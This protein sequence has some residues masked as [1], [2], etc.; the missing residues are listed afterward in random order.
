MTLTVAANKRTITH[1]SAVLAYNGK[2]GPGGGP[3]LTASPA[4]MSIGQGGSF[5]KSV[6]LSLNTATPPIHDPGRVFGKVSGSTVTGTVEQ[7]L[8]G[9]VN[10]CYVETFTAHRALRRTRRSGG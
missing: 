10:K 3:G 7:F 8:G 1:F 5:S 2:C 9:K 6:T 4:S